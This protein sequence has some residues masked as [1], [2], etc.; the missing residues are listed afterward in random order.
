MS[1]GGGVGLGGREQQ[2]L[3]VVTVG[4]DQ[5]AKSAQKELQTIKNFVKKSK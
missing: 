5:V 3:Q 4:S 1:G 2:T